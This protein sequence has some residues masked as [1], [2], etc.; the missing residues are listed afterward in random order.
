MKILLVEDSIKFAKN[1][2]RALEIEGYSVDIAHDGAVGFDM[3]ISPLYDLIILDVMLPKKD[4]LLVCSELRRHG[5]QIPIIMLTAKDELRDK[6][7]GLDSG[8]DD[9]LVKPFGFEELFARL[10]SLLRSKKTSKPLVLK[11]GDLVLSSATHTVKRGGKTIQLTP[12]EYK[13]AF[14]LLR[15]SDRVVSRDELTAELWKTKPVGNE[16]DVHISYLRK[17]INHGH[18]KK[19]ITTIKGVGYRIKT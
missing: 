10:R 5:I 4:G 11:E 18:T 2:K 3:G 13:I 17:K 9:Y 12:K 7:L 14:Y 8:A 15:N 16:L 6:V 19:F 1:L